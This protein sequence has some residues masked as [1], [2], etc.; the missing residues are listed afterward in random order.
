M[1]K[2]PAFLFY[3][4][5]YVS[6]TMGMTFEEK[7]AYVDLL[8]LQFNRG[9]MTLHMIQ[10]TVGHIWEQIKSKF[11]QD[12]DGL[13]YNVRL[14]YEKDRRKNYT[15]SRRNNLNSIDK[16]TKTKPHMNN[17]MKHHMSEHMENE[18]EIE[19]EIVNKNVIVNKTKI[20]KV[21]VP[22][23]DEFLEYA[24]SKEQ[25]VDVND[26]RLKYD[27]WVESD[28]SINRNGKYQKI[29]FW[30]S[31]LLNT[32]PYIKKL[33]VSSGPQKAQRNQYL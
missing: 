15:A 19:N 18:N 30:K 25:N 5:D 32:L 24:K 12:D 33:V 10:H 27:S 6:G 11:K 16:K 4:G 2:D 3:P 1:A 8:M 9:H 7:G 28:W 31:T 13:W 21:L 26:L 20:K 22:N 17:H 14:D 23:F 29:V